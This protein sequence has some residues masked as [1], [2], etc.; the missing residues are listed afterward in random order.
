MSSAQPRL[1][2]GFP[3]GRKA[4]RPKWL[5]S[6]LLMAETPVLLTGLPNT[7]HTQLTRV[8][9][10]KHEFVLTIT[11]YG[12]QLRQESNCPPV[13]HRTAHCWSRYRPR[14]LQSIWTFASRLGL[15]SQ[16]LLACL[17]GCCL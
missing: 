15:L 16:A 8:R 10:S 6:L 4:T 12:L 3:S 1:V 9:T 5:T 13:P 11:L 7:G 14:P 2:S 17:P